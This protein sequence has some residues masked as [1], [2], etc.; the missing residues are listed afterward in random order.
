MDFEY[1]Q[2]IRRC[3]DHDSP[4]RGIVLAFVVMRAV[5]VAEDGL[6]YS[7]ESSPCRTN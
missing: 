7:E 1:R 3:L 5:L 6:R 4:S 2:I